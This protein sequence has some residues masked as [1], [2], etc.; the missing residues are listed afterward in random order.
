MSNR[1]EMDAS[2]WS[3]YC[4]IQ[5]NGLEGGSLLNWENEYYREM[6]GLY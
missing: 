5:W 1:G 4:R 6:V 2:G 3:G